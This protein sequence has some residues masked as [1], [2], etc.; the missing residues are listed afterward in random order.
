[1][2]SFANILWEKTTIL[3]IRLNWRIK[4]WS[5]RIINL[6]HLRK[7]LVCLK[8]F[9]F[10]LFFEELKRFCRNLFWRCLKMTSHDFRFYHPSSVINFFYFS[11]SV[12]HKSHCQVI[13]SR[14]SPFFLKL[15]LWTALF[16]I[17][18][19]KFVIWNP[20]IFFFACTLQCYCLLQPSTWQHLYRFNS[21]WNLRFFS[22]LLN[23]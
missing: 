11:D 18:R 10:Y 12:M 5:F 9:K 7:I 6:K 19:S 16:K 13:K 20:P 22:D 14:P 23:K 8:S 1:M 17:F 3:L 21:V 15:H 2:T 4:S